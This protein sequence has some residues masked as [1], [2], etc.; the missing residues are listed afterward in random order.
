MRYLMF[1]L[2]VPVV[3]MFAAVRGRAEMT[4]AWI[5]ESS[6][7]QATIVSTNPTEKDSLVKEGW[8]IDGAGMIRTDWATGAGALHR[9]SR[10]TD[11]GVERTLETDARQLPVLEKAGYTDEGVVGFVAD[12]DGPE[13]IPVIQ[14]SKGTQRLWVISKESQAKIQQEG[15]SRQGIHFWLWPV[16][17]K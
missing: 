2:F 10:K 7:F 16:T 4:Q 8:K 14:F 15:W 17:A 9:L 13:R 1:R 6:D 11:K 12:S 5:I 3:L